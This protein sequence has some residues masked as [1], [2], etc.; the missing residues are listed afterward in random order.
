MSSN[1]RYLALVGGVPPSYQDNYV[2]YYKDANIPPYPTSHSWEAL[3]FGNFHVP[4]KVAVSDD[5]YAVAATVTSLTEMASLNYWANAA[6]L[7]GNPPPTWEQHL[8]L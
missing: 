7:S 6:A 4:R 3:S 5:G 2:A 8:L 1:G